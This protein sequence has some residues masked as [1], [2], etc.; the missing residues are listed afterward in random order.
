MVSIIWLF[1][2]VGAIL[3]LTPGPLGWKGTVALGF[4]GFSTAAGVFFSIVLFMKYDEKSVYFF[5]RTKPK[6]WKDMVEADVA[7]FNRIC[8]RYRDGSSGT[9]PV[10]F[11]GLSEDIA[12]DWSRSIPEKIKSE[13]FDVRLLA[14]PEMGLRVSPVINYLCLFIWI[15]LTLKFFGF[16]GPVDH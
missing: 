13:D 12:K 14:M 6:Y 5:L 7:P 15:L 2:T 10:D 16:A 8:F 3:L 9:L 4:I 11:F 1:L